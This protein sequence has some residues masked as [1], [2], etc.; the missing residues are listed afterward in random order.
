MRDRD[1]LNPHACKGLASSSRR[2]LSSNAPRTNG[3]TRLSKG[4]ALLQARPPMPTVP[5]VSLDA[6]GGEVMAVAKLFG[7]ATQETV[8]SA[9]Q[10]LREALRAGVCLPVATI[11]CQAVCGMKVLCNVRLYHVA[12]SACLNPLARHSVGLAAPCVTFVLKSLI[13]V[14]SC[15]WV[16]CRR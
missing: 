5:G 1:A 11:K 16:F 9:V 12:L 14:L 10:E 6:A 13:G 7:S 15:R 4:V 3:T 2:L 8:G